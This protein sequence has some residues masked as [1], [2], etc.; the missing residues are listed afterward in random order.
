MRG[1]GAAA[2][3]PEPGTPYLGSARAMLDAVIPTTCPGGRP[4]A[5][6]SCAAKG[7]MVDCAPRFVIELRLAAKGGPYCD[8]P[9]GCRI[10]GLPAAAHRCGKGAERQ[11]LPTVPRR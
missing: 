7:K 1:R 3:R 5:R 2:Q 8:D 4:P 10:Q 9:R 6:K 11:L